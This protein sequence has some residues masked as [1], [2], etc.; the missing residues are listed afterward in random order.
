MRPPGPTLICKHDLV[1]VRQG[2]SHISRQ[3]QADL[4]CLV[5][6]TLFSVAVLRPASIVK[7][8]NYEDWDLFLLNSNHCFHTSQVKTSV[9]INTVLWSIHICLERLPKIH[10]AWK[11]YEGHFSLHLDHNI[12]VLVAEFGH[13]VVDLSPV[14]TLFLITEILIIWSRSALKICTQNVLV[15]GPITWL[16]SSYKCSSAIYLGIHLLPNLM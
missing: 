14:F 4:S 11:S 8:T 6:L 5:H 12:Y 10:R 1:C 16:Y 2:H 7:Y 15:L 13:C 9:R 3:C